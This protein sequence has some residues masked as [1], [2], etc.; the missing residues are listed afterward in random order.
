MAFDVR[1]KGSGS[2]PSRIAIKWLLYCRAYLD[3]WM[4]ADR[5]PISIYNQLLR[6]T[7]FSSLRAY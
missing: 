6:S 5:S 1:S 4:S 3:G 7:Q 2:A